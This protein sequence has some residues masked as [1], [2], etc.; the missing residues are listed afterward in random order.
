MC[1]SVK[2]SDWPKVTKLPGGRAETD[3]KSRWTVL[4][5]MAVIA[6][7]PVSQTYPPHARPSQELWGE[8]TLNPSA[9]VGWG[10]DCTAMTSGMQEEGRE[11]HAASLP[12]PSPLGL[13][14]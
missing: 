2:L 7:R 11:T 13:L 9:G 6:M 14:W 4:S 10:L 8:R 12:L 1:L 5:L 3:T